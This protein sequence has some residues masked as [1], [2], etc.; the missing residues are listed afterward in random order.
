MILSLTRNFLFS[1]KLLSV[2]NAF[3]RSDFALSYLLID[4]NC[5]S[6]LIRIRI[7]LDSWNGTELV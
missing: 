6:F 3:V 4:I 2:V 5:I 7:G 1:R